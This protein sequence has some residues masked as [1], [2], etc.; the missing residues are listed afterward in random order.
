MTKQELRNKIKQINIDFTF[1]F[2]NFIKLV[3]LI[4]IK[5]ANKYVY[6]I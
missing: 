5:K 1:I 6:T 4:Y 2:K 3:I